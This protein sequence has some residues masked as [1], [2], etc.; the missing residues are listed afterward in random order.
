LFVVDEEVEGCVGVNGVFSL[1]W[2][3]SFN[4]VGCLAAWEYDKA[5]V[6]DCDFEY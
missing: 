1:L 5:V 2:R 3:I 4:L 6:L